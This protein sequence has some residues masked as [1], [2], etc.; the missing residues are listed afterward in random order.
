MGGN[1]TGAAAA[2]VSHFPS[3]SCASASSSSVSSIAGVRPAAAIGGLARGCLEA[4]PLDEGV[5]AD[6]RFEDAGGRGLETD[7]AD[8]DDAPV[9]AAGM[10][11]FDDDG[12]A[13][14]SAGAID[15]GS[16]ARMN[17]V[18]A[19]IVA[20]P[21][22]SRIGVHKPPAGLN[23]EVRAEVAA[24]GGSESIVDVPLQHTRSIRA[25]AVV[26]GRLEHREPRLAGRKIGAD[27]S[28]G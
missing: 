16:S 14:G 2:G 12:G 7:G 11:A 25:G 17:V 15:T 1:R 21:H 26:A 6:L 9:R 22:R 10:G 5:A 19:V 27:L 8:D 20:S 13:L 23:L 28:K 3:S 18:C 4:L 24:L